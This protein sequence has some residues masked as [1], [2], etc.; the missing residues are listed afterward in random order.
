MLK[1]NFPQLIPVSKNITTD[2][3]LEHCKHFTLN[4]VCFLAALQLNYYSQ[5][6]LE[7]FQN[8]LKILHHRNVN[9]IKIKLFK[10]LE[11][12]INIDSM[13]KNVTLNGHKDKELAF[14]AY[15]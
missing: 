1:Q 4:L 9:V 11:R 13:V 6:V 14:D 3:R 15:E 12:I 7:P 8:I 2:V 10:Q 5:K